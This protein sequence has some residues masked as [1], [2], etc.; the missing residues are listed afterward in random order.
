MYLCIYTYVCDVYITTPGGHV[1]VCNIDVHEMMEQF[2]GEKLQP[3]QLRSVAQPQPVIQP[4][5]QQ[6]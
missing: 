2:Q 1:D 4:S 5:Q 3:Q 6:P